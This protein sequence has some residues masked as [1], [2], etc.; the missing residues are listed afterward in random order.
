MRKIA[1][2]ASHGKSE[3]ISPRERIL[4]AASD[5]FYRHST[6]PPLIE[7]MHRRLIPAR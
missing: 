2:G 7:P 1:N 6:E 5:L 3:G 4:S